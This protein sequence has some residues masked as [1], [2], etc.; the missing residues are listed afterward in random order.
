MQSAGTLEK[1][2]MKLS[3][4]KGLLCD[5]L[6]VVAGRAHRS[7]VEGPFTD[8]VCQKVFSVESFLGK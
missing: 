6:E 1:I 3:I 8:A 5:L 2:C 4:W 7:S